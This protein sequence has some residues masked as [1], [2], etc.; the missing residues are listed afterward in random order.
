M[1]EDR[2]LSLR[3]PR[4]IRR[5]DD[6]S[7]DEASTVEFLVALYERQIMVVQ[8][9]GEKEERKGDDLPAEE[10][11]QEGQEEEKEEVRLKLDE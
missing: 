10:E 6:K 7:I 3:F 4:F 11:A 5:R 1:H 8:K 9:D 2:G